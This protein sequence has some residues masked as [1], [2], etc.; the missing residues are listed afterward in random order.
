[1]AGKIN[2][3]VNNGT[4]PPNFKPGGQN[5]HSI[6]SLLPPDTGIVCDQ[7]LSSYISM[8]QKMRL[9]IGYAHFDGK[10][11]N[12]PS[13]SEVAALI[14]GDVEQLS[15]DRDIFIESQTRFAEILLAA[16]P[17][18][19]LCVWSWG[20]WKDISLKSYVCGDL[21]KGDIVLNIASSG[22]AS[23][24]PN[25]RTAHLRFKIP[26]N[27]IEDSLCN[28]KPGSSQAMLLLKAKLI[29]WDEASMV[30]RYYYEV[31]DKCLGDIMRFFPT[32][33]KDLSFGGKVVVLSR[34]FRQ[35]F[36]SFHEDRDK[37]SFIQP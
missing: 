29:I 24:L 26:L 21:L 6:G 33:N 31:L 35:F 27:I 4:A 2:R 16:L 34:D 20:Y 12:L 15:K 1:M 11:Y 7:H 22:I 23:F 28:I 36:L 19:F 9:I 30:S 18:F 17:G 37:I 5:Y 32:Y 8:T 13:A 3:G 14:V 10:T 25:G